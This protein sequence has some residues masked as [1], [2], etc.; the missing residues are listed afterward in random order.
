MLAVAVLARAL[1]A[2]QEIEVTLSPGLRTPPLPVRPAGV[3]DRW[4]NIGSCQN[5]SLHNALQVEKML[6][7]ARIGTETW[8]R[9]YT[10]SFSGATGPKSSRFAPVSTG[11][12]RITR[13]IHLVM[14][15]SH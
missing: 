14:E 6:R 2:D 5:T 15:C 13:L 7:I 10:P 12:R 9:P 1:T 3:A 8:N 4:R 11:T